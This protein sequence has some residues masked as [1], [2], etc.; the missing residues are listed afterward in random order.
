MKIAIT[1]GI[2]EGKSTVLRM[3]EKLGFSSIS[4][5]AVAKDVF[6]EPI[7]QSALRA[8]LEIDGQVTPA[9]LAEAITD[10]ETRRAVNSIMHPAIMQKLLAEN[11]TFFEVPLLLETCSHL[12]F[13]AIWLV[14]CG[15]DA[16]RQRL[17]ERYG[18][19]GAKSRVIGQVATLTRISVADTVIDT[20][21][22]LDTTY[23]QILEE[24]RRYGLKAIDS[25]G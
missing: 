5:D 24:Q 16:Q 13:D 22:D 14:T 17:V 25:L 2:A 4:A 20:S 21:T 10:D 1:G 23:S 12:D 9:D 6:W 3:L 11:A 8:L 19:D 18:E 15:E 7:V